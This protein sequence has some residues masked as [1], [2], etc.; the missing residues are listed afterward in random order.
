MCGTDAELDRR[1][2]AVGL[3][4]LRESRDRRRH[5]GQGGDET[6]HCGFLHTGMRNVGGGRLT[7]MGSIAVRLRLACV[8]ECF[9]RG[10][11]RL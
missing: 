9:N 8:G 1:P 10:S 6:A 5:N 11:P 7:T 4:W 2:L 3:G